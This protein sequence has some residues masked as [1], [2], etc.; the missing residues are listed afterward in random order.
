MDS[1]FTS[2]DL[3]PEPLMASGWRWT[4]FIGPFFSI[5][6]LIAGAVWFQRRNHELGK[7]F[8]EIPTNPRFWIVFTFGYMAGPTTDW[9]IFRR[10]WG[11]PFSGIIALMRKQVTN[12]LLP[13]Y[14]GEVYFYTWARRNAHL[15]GTPFGAIKDVAILSA[16]IGNLVT[17]GMLGFAYRL[18]GTL[19]GGGD[20]FYFALSIGFITLSSLVMMFFRGRLF[21]LPRHDLWFVSGIVLIRVLIIMMTTALLWSLALPNIALVWWLV[22]STVKL[23]LSRLPFVPNQQVLF[24]GVASVLIEQSRATPAHI[25]HVIWL[26]AISTTLVHVLVGIILGASDLLK[27]GIRYEMHPAD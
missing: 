21:S 13:S 8:D 27:T 22:L 14:S 15:T 26:V 3:D 11:I 4:R 7:L 12:E 9:V 25:E 18:F 16:L 20:A 1:H 23:L 19:L 5:A 2:D 10:L 6:L 17:L 24:A